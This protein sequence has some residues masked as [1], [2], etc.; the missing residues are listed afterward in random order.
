MNVLLTG[1]SGFLGSRIWAELSR[2]HT[3]TTLGRT[4]VGDRHLTGDLTKRL[5]S[6]AQASFDYIVNAAGKAHSVP[7]STAERADYERVNV[8]GTI[9]LLQELERMPV[10]PKAFVHISTVL[11]YGRS[12]GQLLDETTPIGATD[13]YGLSKV[14]AEAAVRAWGERTGVRVSILRLPLVVA[15]R[16]NG[17]IARL[18][19]AIRHGYYVRIGDRLARRSMVRADD[20]AAVIDRATGVGGTFNLTDGY[21]PG[22]GELADALARYVGR[23]QPIRAVPPVLARAVAIV[24]D[25]INAVVGRRFPLDTVALQKLTHSLTFSDQAARCQLGWKPRPVLDLFR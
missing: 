9:R 12:T 1:A 16:P 20:V 19:N 3:V 10:F 5:P 7:R 13:A 6:L 14:R 22:V 25:G 21:H 4:P 11:V 24:G 8:Q 15:E 2:N 18:M 23:R 17:N